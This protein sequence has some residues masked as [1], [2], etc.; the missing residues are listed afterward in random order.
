MLIKAPKN[1]TRYILSDLL[2]PQLTRIASDC[3]RRFKSARAIDG[4]QNLC[5]LFDSDDY[6]EIERQ[7][8]GI[9]CGLIDRWYEKGDPYVSS[10]AFKVALALLGA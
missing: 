5:S 9:L 8:R 1:F 3:G 7:Y 2:D 10:D 6:Q 4:H